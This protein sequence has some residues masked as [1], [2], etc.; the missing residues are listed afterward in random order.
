MLAFL[1]KRLLS[2][3]LVI[4]GIVT[5]LY[6]IFHLQGNPAEMMVGENSDA[7]TKAAV[8]R[9][10]H[11]DQ[12][13]FV[14][15]LYYLNDLSPLG[16]LDHNDP[17]LAAQSFVRL[18]PTSET[19][20]I[21]L[22]SPWLRRSFQSNKRV[23]ELLAEKLPGT[24]IL[25]LSAMLLACLLGIPL[26]VLSALKKEQW[27]DRLITF[28]T[29]L[30]ISAPSFFIAVIIIRIFAVNLGDW[31]QLNI[32]GYMF[33]ERI[34]EPGFNIHWK[35]LILPAFALGVRPLSIITQLT[36]SSMIEVLSSDYIRT[37]RAK[38]LKE[39]FIVFRHALRNALNPVVTSI[40]GWF[41]S[42][43]AGAFFI[44][45]IFDWQGLGKLTIDALSAND[46]PVILGAA[47]LIG[48]IFVVINLL[49]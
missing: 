39:R 40:S 47:I 48:F 21:A 10:Y 22:K 43:L 6:I 45:T 13:A 5:L 29:L 2:G 15:Y 31:T 4:W 38:G 35:N 1:F 11:L 17:D 42:L 3:F 18:F 32:S 7:E 30:G 20:F 27:S 16:L 25:A 9:A 41:A 8:E 34:F 23:S 44:E 19:G 14:Q 36:R 37:A 49:V 33:E 24:A 12:P 46:Y 26:G 28:V